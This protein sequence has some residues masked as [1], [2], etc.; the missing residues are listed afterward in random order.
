MYLSEFFVLFFLVNFLGGIERNYDVQEHHYKF[1]TMNCCFCGKGFLFEQT[2]LFH[3][4]NY[5]VKKI[6]NIP[7]E[8]PKVS[9]S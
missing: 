2:L 6:S 4:S 7:R 5:H 9:Y 1:I 8:R 3:L